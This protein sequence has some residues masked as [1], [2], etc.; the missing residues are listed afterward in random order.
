MKNRLPFLP[1]ARKKWDCRSGKAGDMGGGFYAFQ[2]S[3]PKM[4]SIL[5]CAA[6]LRRSGLVPANGS[7]CRSESDIYI[8]A[9]VQQYAH[10]HHEHQEG[11]AALLVFMVSMGILLNI[12]NMPMD[13]MNTR[14]EEP[15]AEMKGRG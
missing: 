8:P 6:K 2:H 10:G 13:T 12:S 9:D 4:T 7:I 11:G 1:D 15:P 3:R 14:R 5:G